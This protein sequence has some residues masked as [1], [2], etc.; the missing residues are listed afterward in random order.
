LQKK[1]LDLWSFP[2]I[3]IIHL[4]RFQIISQR[5]YGEKLNTFVDFPIR[6]LDLRKYVIDKSTQ[7]AP[8]YDL[9]AISCHSGGCGGGHYTAYALNQKTNRWYYFNDSSAR[10]ANESEIVSPSAYV[11]FYKK[12]H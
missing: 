2:E 9:Y 1:K 6:G 11:L 5:G 10:P 3:L 12:C 7:S 8:I 4:K